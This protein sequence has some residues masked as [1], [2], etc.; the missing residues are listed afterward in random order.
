MGETA[1]G[2]KDGQ[3]LEKAGVAG[4]SELRAAR[5]RVGLSR[6]CDLWVRTGAG[7]MGILQSGGQGEAG[8]ENQMGATSINGGEQGLELLQWLCRGHVG[9]AGREPG[10]PQHSW[11]GRN[12]VKRAGSSEV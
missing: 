9:S 3:D 11:G 4:A 12:M 8:I 5:D 7:S 10:K 2:A 6:L 1:W